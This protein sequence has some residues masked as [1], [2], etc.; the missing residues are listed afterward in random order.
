[1]KKM[2]ATD[3]I[4]VVFILIFVIAISAPLLKTGFSKMAATSAI[5]KRNL[6]V[7]PSL[8]RSMDALKQFPDDFESYYQ[9]NFGFRDRLT[10][11]YSLLKFHIG[12]SPSERVIIGKDGWL[13]Y[14]G[15]KYTDPVGDYRNINTF[16]NE[17]L[18]AFAQDVQA[19]RNWLNKRGVEYLLV[20]APNK[21]TI[22]PEKLP[23]YIQK[24]SALSALDQI[25]IYM[26]EKTNVTLVD[27]RNPMIAHKSDGLLYFR[28][29]THWNYYGTNIAQFEIAKALSG[30]F[31]DTILPVLYDR[32]TFLT[33]RQAGGDLANF[34]GLRTRFEEEEHLP[35]W[36]NI[37]DLQYTPTTRELRET[38]TTECAS[39]ELSALIFR[40]S[41]F[42]KV[43][44]FFSAYFKHATYIWSPVEFEVLNQYV[45]TNH[46]DVVVEEWAERTLPVRI[47]NAKK[48]HAVIK[49][50]WVNITTWT[51]GFPKKLTFCGFY[52][53]DL[54][55]FVH[56]NGNFTKP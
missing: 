53:L 38:F 29:D 45:N 30:F 22:Y 41:F 40:D 6:A 52:S 2:G 8:P 23:A 48:K 46:P 14:N 28:S 43:Q 50:C 16:S 11:L 27:L 24:V 54:V 44:P 1:M 9:D 42:T 55:V 51:R 32:T 17:T 56:G 31:P 5:E 37:C 36:D 35:I 12:D 13:F 26:R 21:H 19:K 49:M 10:Y 15:D 7:L 25:L 34:I 47:K 18:E 20:I 3:I 39:A 33:Q 4:E